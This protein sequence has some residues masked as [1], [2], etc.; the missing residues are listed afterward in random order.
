[1]IDAPVLG[2]RA[3]VAAV[4][5]SACVLAAIAFAGHPAVSGLAH[6]LLPAP[7]P[8]ELPRGP[9]LER[10]TQ[11]GV[12]IVGVRS[13]PRPAP[14]GALA[15]AEPDSYDVAL[16]RRMTERLALRLELVGLAPA[17]QDAALRTGRVDLVI[18]GAS[19][20]SPDAGTTAAE[21]SYDSDSGTLV[22]LRAGKL[23][24]TDDLRGAPI[25]VAQGT[26]YSATLAERYGARP[27]TYPSSVHAASAFM[28]GEC[29]ALVDHGDVL[30]RLLR[31]EEWRFY[32]TIARGLAPGSDAT[33]RMASGD[34]RSRDWLT[35]AMR[36]W[37]VDGEQ[38]QARSARVGN[39]LFEIG[40]LKDGLVCHS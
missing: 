25:C 37:R 9:I 17:E 33:I 18:A 14:P 6:A 12:L 23:Q 24:G 36:E 22:A 15:P 39:L 11:R 7:S 2:V 16:A 5:A 27:Q 28:A 34:T 8:A 35:A 19:E 30:E 26:G 1:M 21:G 38:Q 29:Q 20:G 32:R 40:L 13:Y 10:A 31:N 3:T 4:G